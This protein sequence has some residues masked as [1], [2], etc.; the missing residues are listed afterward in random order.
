VPQLAGV[1]AIVGAMEQV[2]SEFPDLVW[3]FGN[4]DVARDGEEG[5]IA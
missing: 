1:A 3:M 2:A 5:E 4:V